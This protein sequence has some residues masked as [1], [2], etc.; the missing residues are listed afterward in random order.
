MATKG[1]D[2]YGSWVIYVCFLF[3][4]SIP[5]KNILSFNDEKALNFLISHS[6]KIQ[7]LNINEY[8]L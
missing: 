3:Q 5:S 4:K 8:E 1:K 7:I 6:K 2:L